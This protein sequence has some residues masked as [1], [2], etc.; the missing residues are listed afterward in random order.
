M[1]SLQVLDVIN[2][3]PEELRNVDVSDVTVWVDPLDGTA[4]FTQGLLD[5]VTVLI[6]KSFNFPP[7]K[8]FALYLK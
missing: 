1:I 4:E 2:Q 6:G 5:H 7:F 8:Y 3:F